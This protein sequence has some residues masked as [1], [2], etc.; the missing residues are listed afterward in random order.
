MNN[1]L[2]FLTEGKHETGVPDRVYESPEIRSYIQN[3]SWTV[4][5]IFYNNR[6]TKCRTYNF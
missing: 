6:Q 3:I 2:K 5:S 4:Q 1:I